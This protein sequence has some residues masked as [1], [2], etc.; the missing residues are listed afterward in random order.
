MPPPSSKRAA[1]F[2]G[3][4]LPTGVFCLLMVVVA[5]TAMRSSSPEAPDSV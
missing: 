1:P 4:I 2:A 3:A 5:A